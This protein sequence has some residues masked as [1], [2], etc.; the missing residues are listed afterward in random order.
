[1][2]DFVWSEATF[3]QKCWALTWFI[4]KAISVVL[5]SFLFFVVGTVVLVVILKAMVILGAFQ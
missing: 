1:M 3:L 4:R 2:D 5:C